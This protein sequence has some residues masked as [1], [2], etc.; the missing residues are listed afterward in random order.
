[1]TF[2]SFIQDLQDLQDYAGFTRL[3]K[4]IQ[5]LQDY[6]GLSFYKIRHLSLEMT[7]NLK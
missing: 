7:K 4:I 1:M 3:Y 2:F 5:D 6:T